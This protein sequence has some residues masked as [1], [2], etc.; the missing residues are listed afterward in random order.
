MINYIHDLRFNT[1]IAEE[2]FAKK[3]AYTLGP[4]ELREKMQKS[5][6]KV[7]DV[8]NKEDYDKGHIKGSVSMPYSD[9]EKSLVNLS[10]NQLHIIC[11][12]NQQCHLGAKACYLLTSNDYPAMDLEGGYEVWQR[13][14]FEIEFLDK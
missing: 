10:K 1:N 6:I 3:L 9:L 14:H 8:R 13:F 12:Y 2:F 4:V 7:I 11:C 5:D